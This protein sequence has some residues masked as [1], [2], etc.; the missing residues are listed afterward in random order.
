MSL[1]ENP[2]PGLKLRAQCKQNYTKAF[3]CVGHHKLWKILKEIETPDHLTCL[4]RNPYAGQEAIVRTGHEQWTGSKSGKEYVKAV[5]G[6]P[7]CLFSLNTEY[8]MRNARLNKPQAGIKTAGENINNLRYV[9]DSILI[10]ESEEL[11]SLLM[12]VK[13]ESEEVA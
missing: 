1:G 9:D 12:R 10:A 3:D 6:H 2:P 7:P 11:K 13:D 5:C 8:I 4:L